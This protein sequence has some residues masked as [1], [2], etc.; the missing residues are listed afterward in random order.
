MSERLDIAALPDPASIPLDQIPAVIGE[1]EKM[2]AVLWSRVVRPEASR[3]PALAE[4]ETD[5]SQAQAA[6]RRNLPL[7]TVRFLTRTGR[8]PSFKAGRRRLL[9]LSDLDAYLDRCRAR[10]VAVTRLRD[11]AS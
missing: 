4:R 1:L 2:K 9:R 10:G 6:T 11:V 3:P 7:R 8:V 5:V